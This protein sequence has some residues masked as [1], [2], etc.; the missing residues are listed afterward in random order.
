MIELTQKQRTRGNALMRA[1]DAAIFAERA[2]EETAKP[3]QLDL[4]ADIPTLTPGPGRPRTARL[5]VRGSNR[6]GCRRW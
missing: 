6:R 3:V 5:V 1:L 2:A 4:F